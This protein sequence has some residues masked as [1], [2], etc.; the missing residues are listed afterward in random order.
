MFN[1]CLRLCFNCRFEPIKC[2]TYLT[3]VN[4]LSLTSSIAQIG[5]SI[6]LLTIKSLV[7]T[8]LEEIFLEVTG[9]EPITLCMQGIHS[10]SLSYT[11]LNRIYIT[12]F[13][14]VQ[15]KLVFIVCRF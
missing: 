13:L 6:W 3:N 5:Q 12:S 1:V 4:V 15:M 2:T 14:N 9:L 11:P 10:T 7:Q 8:Q